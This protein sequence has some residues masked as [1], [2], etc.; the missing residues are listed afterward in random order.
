[1]TSVPQTQ[2]IVGYFLAIK[3]LSLLEVNGSWALNSLFQYKVRAKEEAQDLEEVF[4]LG[5]L[6]I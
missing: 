6:P 4:N 5:L 3:Q 2:T 1:M